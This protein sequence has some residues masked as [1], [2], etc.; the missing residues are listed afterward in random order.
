M[1]PG[2]VPFQ[3]Y[4]G[5]TGVDFYGVTAL[6]PN[7]GGRMRAG[8]SGTAKILIARRT[9]AGMAGKQLRDFVDRKIW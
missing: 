3:G 6:V 7:A 8:M 1:E 5:L 9:L 4:K 2:L